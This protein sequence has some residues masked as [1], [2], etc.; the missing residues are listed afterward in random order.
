[1]LD[2]PKLVGD[3]ASVPNHLVGKLTAS[4]TEFVET[5]GSP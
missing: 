5:T 1:M 3:A 2:L 4:P